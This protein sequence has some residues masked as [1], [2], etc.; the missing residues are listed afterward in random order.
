MTMNGLK[1]YQLTAPEFCSFSHTDRRGHVLTSPADNIPMLR[2]PDGRWCLLGNFYMQEQ[3]NAGYSRK[4]G[5]GTLKTYGVNIS[6]LIRYCHKNQTDFIDLT[7]SQFTF[8]VKTLQG[9]RRRKDPEVEARD[10][11]SVIAIGRRCLDFLSRVGRYY[12]DDEFV[13]PKGRICAEMREYIIKNVGSRKKKIVCRYWHHH[14]FPT[15][16][17][18]KKG[19]PISTENV[20]KLRE[21]VLPAS[22]SVYMRKRRYVMLTLLEITGARRIEVATV[23]VES[24]REA[25][26]MKDPMVK[27]ETA[28]RRGG[29]NA[30]R[31]V[32]VTHHDI[33]F[34]MD[35]IDKNRPLIIKKTCGFDNDKGS[36]LVSA[37]TGK[38]LKPNTI[39]QEIS[40]LSGQAGFVEKNCP[41]MFRPR[42]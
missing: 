29:Q 24:V 20:A 7:D 9:E 22:H 36:L 16:D 2:W 33:S 38:P 42:F 15:P 26:R 11:N 41:K 6:P 13:G 32:P 27:F 3:Y 37:T 8:F 28:K 31:L 14:S 12:G 35:F 5:G 23:A 39:T 4:G 30:T 1:L 10:A 40:K 34:L 18:K 21:A 25:A 19:L 17:P